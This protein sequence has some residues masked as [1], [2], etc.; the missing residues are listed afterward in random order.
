MSQSK[1]HRLIIYSL[2]TKKSKSSTSS[3]GRSWNS[4]PKYDIILHH[5]LSSL[6][7]ILNVYQLRQL[8]MRCW[9]SESWLKTTNCWRD[10]CGR[11]MVLLWRHLFCPPESSRSCVCSVVSVS[12]NTAESHWFLSVH[13]VR[14]WMSMWVCMQVLLHVCVCVCVCVCG[15]RS[16]L[17]CVCVLERVNRSQLCE[18]D[19][20]FPFLSSSHFTFSSSFYISLS[21][22]CWSLYKLDSINFIRTAV[23]RHKQCPVGF[24]HTD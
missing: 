6:N 10:R 5:C 19:F 22:Y 24:K 7:D 11:T 9:L 17:V 23:F 18:P 12:L 3:H 1:T 15:G 20:L 14:T 13:C 21:F 2:M 8:W 16:I 4:L